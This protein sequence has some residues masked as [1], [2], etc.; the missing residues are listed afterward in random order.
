MR[1]RNPRRSGNIEDRRGMRVP[2]KAI[3]G[4]I[5]G[6]IVLILALLLSGGDPGVIFDDNTNVGINNNPGSLYYEG[7][8]PISQEERELADFVSVVLADTEDTWNEIFAAENLDYR[9]PTLVLFSGAVE[10]A[11]G[12]AQSS[13]GPFYCPVDEKVYI[14]L[15]FYRDL[16]DTFG[17]PGDFAQA[18]IIAHEVGHHVQNQIGIMEE[19][20]SAQQQANNQVDANRLSVSLELQADC[21]AGVWA[22]NA[23]RARDILEQGDIEEGLNAASSIG[24]DRLQMESQGQVTPDSFTHG[25]SVQRVSW[26]ERG[27]EA[28]D[29][30]SCNSFEVT[31]S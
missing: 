31:S 6:L 13:V 24:D 23:D 12:F 10:S 29:I 19:V 21:F 17:A 18:Y 20:N 1:W 30:N 7:T 14:D 4:G 26:F 15:S 28:S 3:G 2:M 9:E 8:T 11:C 16:R 27:L 25:S 22:Y 5:G